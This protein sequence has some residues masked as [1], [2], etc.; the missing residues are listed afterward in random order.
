MKLFGVIEL[1]ITKKKPLRTESTDNKIAVDGKSS[2]QRSR[3]K[4][5][6]LK[7]TK[8]KGRVRDK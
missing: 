4:K 5:T 6:D 2:V 8:V 3:K 7:R 1:T